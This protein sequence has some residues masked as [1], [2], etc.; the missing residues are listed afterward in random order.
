MGGDHSSHGTKLPMQ[1]STHSLGGPQ[2]IPTSSVSPW[3]TGPISAILGSALAF[4][5]D[6]P[7]LPP[8]LVMSSPSLAARYV[9]G[10]SPN[11]TRPFLERPTPFPDQGETRSGHAKGQLGGLRAARVEGNGAQTH[12]QPTQR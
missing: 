6:V 3:C 12:A 2:C 7:R 9:R 1:P 5:H 11:T 4:P 10:Q 8:P